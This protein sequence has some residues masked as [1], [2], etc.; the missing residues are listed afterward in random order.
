M[1]EF[2]PTPITYGDFT[3]ADLFTLPVGSIVALVS[4]GLAHKM[5]NE[6]AS[7]VSAAKAKRAADTTEGALGPMNDAEVATAQV[8]ARKAMWEAIVNGTLGVRG[9]AAPRVDPVT[10]RMR[11]IAGDEVTATLKANKL[12]VPRGDKTVSFPVGDK[13]ESFT[14]GQL[15]DRRL[16]PSRGPS[17][18][19]I[20]K[21]AE[22]EL[23]EL[24]K[25]TAAPEFDL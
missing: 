10:K 12:A 3:H 17:A 6:V 24:A 25:A 7:K 8:D 16:D 14:F 19:R 23:R 20:R 22:R 4:S 2:N 18:E 15:I 21:Q 11:E 9:P 13:T 1:P 5:G